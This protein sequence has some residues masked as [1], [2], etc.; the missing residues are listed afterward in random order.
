MARGKLHKFRSLGL[1]IDFARLGRFGR[2]ACKLR[3]WTTIHP[4][5]GIFV[6]AQQEALGCPQKHRPMGK[7]KKATPIDPALWLAQSQK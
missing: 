4:N 6:P 3:I 2:F 7:P 1:L 5:A